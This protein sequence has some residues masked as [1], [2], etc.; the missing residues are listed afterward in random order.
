MTVDFQAKHLIILY[1]N[2][3]KSFH[4]TEYC[5]FTQLRWFFSKVKSSRISSKWTKSN[6]YAVEHKNDSNPVDLTRIFGRKFQ[7]ISTLRKYLRLELKKWILDGNETHVPFRVR[8]T[9]IILRK[10]EIIRDFISVSTLTGK[11]RIT[12]LGLAGSQIGPCDTM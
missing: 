11:T 5:C 3:K 2:M 6:S 10:N 8:L 4:F 1:K 9:S 7:N 12:C